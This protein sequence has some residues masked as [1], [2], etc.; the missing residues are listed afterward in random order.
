MDCLCVNNNILKKF[1]ILLINLFKYFLY[2]IYFFNFITI[3][4]DKYKNIFCSK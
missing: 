3:K 1:V 4:R 2:G